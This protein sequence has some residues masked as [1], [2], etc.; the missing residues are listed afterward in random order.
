MYM[1][2][3]TIHTRIIHVHVCMCAFISYHLTDVVKK[4]S[5]FCTKLHKQTF[6]FSLQN[7]QPLHLLPPLSLSLS[8]QD[9]ES[10]NSRH[11]SV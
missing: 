11:I 1:Y 6:I 4:C 10:Y 9:Y 5:Q 2:I 3:Y 8:S 7:T